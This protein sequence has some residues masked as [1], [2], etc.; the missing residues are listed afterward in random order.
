MTSNVTN[1]I[2][3]LTN[4]SGVHQSGKNCFVRPARVVMFKRYFRYLG[5]LWEE[6]AVVLLMAVQVVVEVAQPLPVPG[7][8]SNLIS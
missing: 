3:N 1:A 5:Y 2:Q 4:I 6:V 8:D 7:V